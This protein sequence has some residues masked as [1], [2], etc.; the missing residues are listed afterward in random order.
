MGYGVKLKTPGCLGQI[1][2]TKGLPPCSFWIAFSKKERGKQ[3]QERTTTKGKGRTRGMFFLE[4]KN[5]FMFLFLQRAK[6]LYRV[7]PTAHALLSTE[8]WNKSD[9]VPTPRVKALSANLVWVFMF[10]TMAQ[11]CIIE[12]RHG[13]F[14]KIIAIGTL[15]HLSTWGHPVVQTQRR[16]GCQ[17]PFPLKQH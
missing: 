2:R 16:E 10:L 3:T 7:S 13:L 5:L 9:T 12:E 8:S 1:G 15:G 11:G 6:N 4:Q 14:G 17:I